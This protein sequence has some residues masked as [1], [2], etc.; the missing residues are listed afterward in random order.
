MSEIRTQAVP[1]VLRVL[2][3]A[4]WEVGKLLGTRSTRWVLGVILG[5]A[6]VI[7]AVVGYAMIQDDAGVSWDA[8]LGMP[9]LAMMVVGPILAILVMTS[10][11]STRGV[12]SY[13]LLEPRRTVVLLAKVLASLAAVLLVCA[14]IMVIS[15][16]LGGA[17]ALGTGQEFSA[18]AVLSET[19]GEMLLTILGMTVMGAALGSA[20]LVPGLAL[21]LLFGGVFVLGPAVAL[22][23]GDWGPYVNIFSVFALDQLEGVVSTLVWVALPFGIGVWR[24]HTGE[25]A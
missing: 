3:I 6:F 12:V 4:G 18:D 8:L 16:V 7:T 15:F 20:L 2:Q 17:I 1:A 23:G 5:I 21:V 13:F 25:V 10:D 22:L 14:A 19:G 24:N 9:G 11:W